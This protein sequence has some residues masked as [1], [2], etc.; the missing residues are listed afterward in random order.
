M[1]SSRFSFKNIIYIYQ[2]LFKKF[3]LKDEEY[4]DTLIHEICHLVKSFNRAKVIDG[5]I[6]APTGLMFDEYDIQGNKLNGEYSINVGIEE[7]TNS[8]DAERVT[9]LVLGYPYQSSAYHG[10]SQLVKQ[11]MEN[12]D[13]REAIKK[14]QFGDD[15]DLTNLFG[16]EEL[17]KLMQNFDI[18]IKLSYIS[19]SDLGVDF[20]AE[21]DRLLE[22][23]KSLDEIQE[24]ITAKIQQEQDRIWAPYHLAY[25]DI[26]K[27]IKNF[28]SSRQLKSFEDARINADKEIIEVLNSLA[29]NQQEPIEDLQSVPKF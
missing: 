22:E 2:P 27:F 17:S 23:G 4:L 18:I 8:Y 15:S 12:S 13:I 16:K 9:E 21:F 11:F 3:D 5:K 28:T 29:I 26:E 10:V 19:E 25:A 7:A 1:E 6:I 20:D 24:I 14:A